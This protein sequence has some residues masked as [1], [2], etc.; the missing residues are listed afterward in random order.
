MRDAKVRQTLGN[1]AIEDVSVFG[2]LKTG[3]PSGAF[4]REE[5]SLSVTGSRHDAIVRVL[6]RKSYVDGQTLG[7]PEVMEIEIRD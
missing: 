4:A 7:E 1:V 6:I 3:D 2:I 5:H